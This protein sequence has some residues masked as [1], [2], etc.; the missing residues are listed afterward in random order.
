MSPQLYEKFTLQ[1]QTQ[2][3]EYLM[4]LDGREGSYFFMN[5]DKYTVECQR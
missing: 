5:K 3:K 2:L 4:R 1:V